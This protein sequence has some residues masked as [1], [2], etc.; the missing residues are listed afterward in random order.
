MSHVIKACKRSGARLVFFDNVY[1]YGKVVG[2]TTESTSFNR[3]GAFAG[4]DLE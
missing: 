2:P 3:L 1:M 4:S